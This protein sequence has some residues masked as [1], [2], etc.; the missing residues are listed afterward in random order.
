MQH[1]RTPLDF[2]DLKDG[3]TCNPLS[4]HM[5]LIPLAYPVYFLSH[6]HIL[7]YALAAFS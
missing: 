6:F 3:S 5:S 4:S 7:F 2:G 1:T